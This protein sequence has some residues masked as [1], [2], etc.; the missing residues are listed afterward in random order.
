MVCVW[1]RRL[2]GALYAAAV[3]TDRRRSASRLRSLL[4]RYRGGRFELAESGGASG[5]VFY[6]DSAGRQFY[7]G[8]F[9]PDH[10]HALVEVLNLT[11]EL[12]AA[13]SH[14]DAQ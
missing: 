12:I 5:M 4:A 3:D 1:A 11:M 8:G 9:Q 14:R 6:R 7:I 13:S 2:L 10:A